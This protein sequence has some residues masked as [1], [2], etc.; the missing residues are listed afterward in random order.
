MDQITEHV[1]RIESGD[2]SVFLIVLPES[3]TLIDAGFPGT[4]ALVEAGV[5]S[6]ARLPEEIR[7]VLVTHCHPDHAGGLSEVKR[8]TGAQAWMHPADAELVRTGRA[9]RPWKTAPGLRNRYFAWRV[10]ARAPGSYPPASVEREVLSGETVP[11][12]GGIK[13][14]GTPGHS[15]GHLVYLWPGDGGVLFVGDA[16][17]HKRRLA[18]AT[19]YEDMPLGLESL[20]ALSEQQFE[21]ACFAHGAPVVG[22]AALEFRKI[23][24]E[25]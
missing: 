20:R 6:L 4:M 1:Y 3:L 14:L 2:V 25:R 17:S 10:I 16:A 8:A 7:D 19:I 11:V 23:W 9:F 12:A 5:R 24:G 18:P 22:G 21:T 13:A 15:V